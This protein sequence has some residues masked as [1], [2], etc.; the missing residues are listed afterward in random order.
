MAFDSQVLVRVTALKDLVS[1]VHHALDEVDAGIKIY[2]ELRPTPSHRRLLQEL[3]DVNHA[4]KHF[5]EQL[6]NVVENISASSPALLLTGD[7][8]FHLL[9][10]RTE[11]P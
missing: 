7:S 2:D 8:K 9:V 5:H 3:K 10:S 11:S 6:V 4:T 1:K